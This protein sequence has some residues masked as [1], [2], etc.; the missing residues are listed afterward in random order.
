MTKGQCIEKLREYF[1]DKSDISVVYLFGSVA[2]G[3]A[4][5]NS[6]VDVAV[7]FV[8]GLPLTHRFERKL[9]IANDLEDLLKTEVDVVDLESADLYFIHQLMLDKVVIL[10]RDIDRRVSFE[11]EKR[12][13]YFDMKYFYDL[14]HGQALIRLGEKGRRYKNG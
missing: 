5:R 4:T 1:V 14:Y 8:Q 9:E 2:K 13:K 11:V 7:L 10:E 6:D 12:K 3:R